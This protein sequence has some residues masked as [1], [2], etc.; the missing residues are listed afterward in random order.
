M[1]QIK[2]DEGVLSR[3]SVIIVTVSRYNLIKKLQVWFF[4]MT[5]IKPF[6]VVFTGSFNLDEVE[7]TDDQSNDEKDEPQSQRSG[8]VSIWKVIV[9]LA[10]IVI[11]LIMY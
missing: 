8:G 1:E 5:E 11:V 2:I 4:G 10:V 3:G 7:V 6:S 9:I